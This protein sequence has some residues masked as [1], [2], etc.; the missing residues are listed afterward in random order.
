[1][2]SYTYGANVRFT[3]TNMKTKK[4]QIGVRLDADTRRKLQQAA[5]RERRTISDMVRLVI[6][7]WLKRRAA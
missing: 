4:T 7:D 3:M 6:E 2:T 1:M 5:D